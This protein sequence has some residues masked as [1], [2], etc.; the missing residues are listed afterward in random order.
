MPSH[1]GKTPTHV[2]DYLNGPADLVIRHAGDDHV[3][4]IVGNG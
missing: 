1:N 3:V 2:S 4:R